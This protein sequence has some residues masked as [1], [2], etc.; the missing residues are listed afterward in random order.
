VAYAI[1]IR[2]SALRELKRI[3]D[4]E[5]ARIQ[6]R[7]DDLGAEPRPHGSEKLVGGEE[8]YRIRVGAYRV[9]YTVDDRERIVTI[10][11]VGHRGDVY[12]RR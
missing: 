3:P 2:S 10:H 11:K 7:I 6:V 8:E 4:R 12:R 1:R 9:I 5:S